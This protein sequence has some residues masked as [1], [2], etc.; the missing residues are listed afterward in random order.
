MGYLIGID[1]GTTS[2]KAILIEDN[3]KVVSK[4]SYEYPIKM[5]HQSWAEQDAETWWDATEY[6]L[7]KVLHESKIR[8]A[9]IEGIGLSGQMHGTV[10]IGRNH[11]SL[12][13]AIIWADQRSNIECNE[14]YQTL[15]RDLLIKVVCNPIVPGF[16]APTLLWMKKHDPKFL[17]RTYKV[18]SPKDYVRLKLTGKIATDVTDASATLLFDVPKRKW[19]KEVLEALEIRP[20]LLCEDIYESQDVTGEVTSWAADKTSL[21]QGIPVVAGGGDQEVQAVGNGV[22]KPGI[23][24]STIGTGGILFSV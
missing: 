8:A 11:E 22:I 3:G 9:E 23:A 10:F 21:P 7:T 18:L 12:R 24:S 13:P 17:E 20:D 4:A 5:S 16:M 1:I 19:S 2:T 14:M 15:G 6:T